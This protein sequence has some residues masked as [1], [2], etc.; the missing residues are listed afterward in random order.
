VTI[1]DCTVICAGS[2]ITNDVTIGEHVAVNLSCTI[3]QD[4]IV[5]HCAT[6]SFCVR[7]PAVVK[8]TDRFS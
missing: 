6:L 4:A 1:G 8:K 2:V 3:G 7:V 5:E